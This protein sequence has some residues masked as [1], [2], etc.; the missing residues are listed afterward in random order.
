MQTTIVENRSGSMNADTI[1]KG[2]ALA[3]PRSAHS[4]HPKEN[5]TSDVESFIRMRLPSAPHAKNDT[6]ERPAVQHN[7]YCAKNN[8]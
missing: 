1:L 2:R 7:A 6:L 5:Y 3:K 8:D 4:N